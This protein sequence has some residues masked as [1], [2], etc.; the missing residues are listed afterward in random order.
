MREVVHDRNHEPPVI[1]ARVVVERAVLGRDGRLLEL[2]AD[3][4]ERHDGTVLV[5]HRLDQVPV[6]VEDSRRLL[7]VRGLDGV[8]RRQVAGEVVDDADRRP[9]PHQRRRRDDDQCEQREPE[10][11][12][13]RLPF[14]DG[15][16]RSGT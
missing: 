8:D 15:A 13:L 6:A 1:D 10:Q 3:L 2:G 4:V 11:P 7:E 12:V 14:L 9:R 5:V 16:T